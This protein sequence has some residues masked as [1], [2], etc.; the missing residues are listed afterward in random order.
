M[1]IRIIKDGRIMVSTIEVGDVIEYYEEKLRDKDIRIENIYISK[2][3]DEWGKPTVQTFLHK[4]WE[5]RQLRQIC[6]ENTDR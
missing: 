3:M 5:S 2:S 4:G 1:P 6:K